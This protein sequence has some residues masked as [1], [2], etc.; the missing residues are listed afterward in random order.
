MSKAEMI[1]AE[2]F[3][4]YNSISMQFI[5]ELCDAGIVEVVTIEDVQYIP[6][7]NV[8]QLE[9]L[10]RLH[11]DLDINIGGLEAVAHLLQQVEDL[12]REVRSLSQRLYVYEQR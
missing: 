11:T 2:D 8:S 5:T 6:D 1:T 12:Q 10:A 3:C 7:D 4:V 9:K